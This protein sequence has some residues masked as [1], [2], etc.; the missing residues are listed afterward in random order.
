MGCLLDSFEEHDGPV[1]GVDFHKSQPLFVSGGDD[2]KIKVWN[3]KLR[4]CLFTLLGHLDYIRT[5]QFH[6]EYP[7]IVSASDDQTIRIWN[8]Q[9]RN[10]ISVLTGHNHYVMCAE[11]H[12]CDDLVVSASLDNT[13][14]VWDTSGLR[15]K[16]VRGAPQDV[17]MNGNNNAMITRVNADLFGGTDAIVKYVLEGHDRGVNW[18][19]FHDNLP[20]IVSGADDRL[21]KLW[22]MSETKAWEVDT[23]RGH[24]NNVS[25]VMFVP[26]SN[27]MVSNSEDRSIRVWDISRRTAVQSFRRENDRFW[28]LTAHPYQNLLAAGHDSGMTVF[29]LERER[30]A[31]DMLYNNTELYYMKDRFL[32][33][34]TYGTSEHKV[35][36]SPR[37]TGPSSLGS[38]PRALIYNPHNP[39][40]VNIL[41]T[42]GAE[43]GSY[44]L[45]TLDKNQSSSTE[46]PDSRRG[47]ATGVAFISRS[48]F[49]ALDRSRQLV[50]YNMNNE[51]GKRIPA[52][53]PTTDAI[54][55]AHTVDRVLLRSGDHISLYDIAARRIVAEAIV[56]N[57]RYISWNADGSLLAIM[58]KHAVVVCNKNLE[59]QCTVAET[60]RVK[61]G[62]WAPQ[63]VFVYATLNHIKFCIPN[64]DTGVI[65]TLDLP[66]YITRVTKNALYCLNRECEMLTLS[67]DTTEC[68]FK[69]ALMK[70]QYGEVIRMIR[71]S[72]LCGQAIIAYLQAKGFPEVAL[73]FVEDKKTRFNLAIECG[74]LEVA[75]QSAEEVD[76]TECWN[77][78]AVEALRQGNQSVV[79]K[80]YQRTKDFERLSFLYLITGNTDKLRKMLL[81]AEMRGDVM[82]RFH[83]ALYLGDAQARVAILESVGQLPLAYVTAASHGL[84]EDTERLKQALEEAEVPVPDVDVDS[85][86]LLMP[87]NPITRDTEENWPLLEVS[88]SIINQALLGEGIPNDVDLSQYDAEPVNV[89]E[90]ESS[91]GFGD[92]DDMDGGDNFGMSEDDMGMGDWGDDDEDDLF[93]DL[94]DGDDDGLTNDGLGGGEGGEDDLDGGVFVAPAEGPSKPMSWIRN[95][96][97]A[98]DHVAA[99]SFN[100]A[101]ELLNRQIGV[102]NFRPL[103][104]SMM[105]VYIGARAV[106]PGLPG[107]PSPVYYLERTDGGSDG[108]P[109]DT[110][111]SFP[112]SCMQLSTLIER[113]R[114]AYKLFQAGK[115]KDSRDAFRGILFCVPFV[116]ATRSEV[117]ELKDIMRICREYVTGCLLELKRKETKDEVRQAELA[118]YFTRCDLQPA[119]LVLVLN[120]AMTRAFKL[121]A[122]I[123]AASFAQ[124][125]LGMKEIE[126]HSQEKIKV[127]ATKILRASEKQG[128]NEV[129]IDYDTSEFSICVISQK[130]IRASAQFV[131]CPCC[132]ALAASEFTGK[133][134]PVCTLSPMGVE[135]VGMISSMDR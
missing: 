79:E 83:N 70:K 133:L 59:Q 7:W 89:D 12:P 5:V 53:Y 91:N 40:E 127:K 121:K 84:E 96:S 117:S 90:K 56:P 26:K 41:V 119:H 116:V 50:V 55:Q 61:S 109:A 3:F 118:A 135:T 114:Y 51:P 67:I 27:Y 93:D 78:L 82:S 24:T 15:K 112:T 86:T 29:K 54:F 22:R 2:Y 45:L 95:S 44:E 65:R 106:I 46:V 101:M 74:N 48:K 76:D 85:A 17:D 66:V 113:L 97:L 92:G 102:V 107:T 131:K 122:F 1:R 57:A 103:K 77:R 39:A 34:Y 124:K 81:I 111:N 134:C 11:F 31:Y 42:S 16:N 72:R 18:V 9:S 35:K 19:C 21:I 28:I 108:T 30:P 123:A 38:G 110:G 52:P 58:C 87:P 105:E 62:A 115:F 120:L 20:L 104:D 49:V 99:G 64:G 47:S 60:V 33:Q 80:A 6:H 130:P 4:R 10:S 37:G 125:L 25:C 73:H 126:H 71:N 88:K 13:V 36:V 43:G 129:D 128:K 8:W 98:A 94:G 132:S 100:T 69:V 32:R 63:N 75:M 68:F 23:M 14:R